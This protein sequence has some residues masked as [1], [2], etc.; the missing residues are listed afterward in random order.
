MPVM[1]GL[2]ATRLIR[3]FEETGSWEAAVNAGIFHH[4]TTTP[5][6]TP[7]SS[8]SSSSRNRMPIIAMTANSMSESAE[9]CYE[10]GMDSFV[11]KPITFQK[12]K[13]CLERYLPQPPL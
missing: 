8:S 1:D 12:L 5:S 6:W 11:S 2:E 13:E 4:P 3:S 7:S 10:N 9:E